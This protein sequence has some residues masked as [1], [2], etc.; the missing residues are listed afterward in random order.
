M[1]SY[2][3]LTLTPLF[4]C[5]QMQQ[6]FSVLCPPPMYYFRIQGIK[7][8]VHI[9]L[10]NTLIPMYTRS[11]SQ[12]DAALLSFTQPQRDKDKKRSEGTYY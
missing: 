3:L 1:S 9:V 7:A 6:L 10:Y 11:P 12:L 4:F 5:G 2:D 8:C